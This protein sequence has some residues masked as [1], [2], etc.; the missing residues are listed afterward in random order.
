V[1]D[2]FVSGAAA[3]HTYRIP[4]LAVTAAGALLA[5][6]EGRRHIRSDVGEIDLLLRFSAWRAPADGAGVQRSAA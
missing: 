6:C 2:L 3:Y 1:R 4:A 5:F